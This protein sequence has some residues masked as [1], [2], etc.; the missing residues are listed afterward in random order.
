[1]SLK[2]HFENVGTEVNSYC[3]C[4][5]QENYTTLNEGEGGSDLPRITQLAAENAA[6]HVDALGTHHEVRIAVSRR[7]T[8]IIGERGCEHCGDY[9]PDQATMRQQL[10]AMLG[11]LP[12]ALEAPTS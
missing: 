1:M 10:S 2:L 4:G 9:V 6:A 7:S 3:E 12:P 8:I 5:W 11:E